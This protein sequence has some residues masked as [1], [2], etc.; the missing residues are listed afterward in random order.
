MSSELN[1]SYVAKFVID[2]SINNN[3]IKTKIYSSQYNK[4]YAIVNYDKNIVTNDDIETGLYRSVVLNPDT[5]KVLCFS[6][7]KSVPLDLFKEKF[8]DVNDPSLL[9]TNIIEG[10]MIN[11]FYD[12][13]LESW[14]IAT[15]GAVGGNYWF[16]RNTYE[17]NPVKQSTFLDMF[18][19]TCLVPRETNIND[20]PFVKNL[21]KG[22]CY[23]FV[24]QHPE[25]HI[26]FKIN[27][28]SL[29]IVAVYEIS[30]E[31]WTMFDGRPSEKFNEPLSSQVYQLDIRNFY[32]SFVEYPFIRF[33]IS[34]YNNDYMNKC[35]TYDSLNKYCSLS[36]GYH[37]IGVMITDLKTGL[38]TKI[39]NPNYKALKDIR[40]NHP[41][42]QYQ[43]FSL[44][45]TGKVQEFL[46]Y[47]PMY[48]SIFN[49]FNKQTEDFITK[50]HDAY[51]QYFIKRMG[52]QVKF[53]KPIFIHIHKIHN[54]IYIPSLSQTKKVIT[55]RLVKEEYFNNFE[56]KEMLYHVN[57]LS[58]EME[59][60]SKKGEIDV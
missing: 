15:K 33:P 10:T 48:K 19:D 12:P 22:C 4:D 55:R 24:L 35:Q 1:T 27:R 53:D 8:P 31:E 40:S 36:S 14:E 41:N 29:T 25:N 58:R 43:Y 16:Y 39:I 32:N 7:P 50:L 21:T 18:K 38:R 2:P 37:M 47:F 46:Y 49:K 11:L 20:I 44:L 57:Y 30:N 26:V 34:E 54:N 59:E 42:L 52:N 9:V 13:R 60:F 5:K 51:V 23:S 17:V 56:P 6:P 45:K 28:P 3:K